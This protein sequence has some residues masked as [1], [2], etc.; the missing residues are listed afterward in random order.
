MALLD[1]FDLAASFRGRNLEGD[2][3]AEGGGVFGVSFHVDEREF[4]VLLGPSGSGKSVTLL[5]IL[6][7]LSDPPGITRGRVRYRGRSILPEVAEHFGRRVPSGRRWMRFRRAHL[8]L[9]APYRGREMAL[10]QQDPVGSLDPQRSIGSQLLTTARASRPDWDSSLARARALEV[11]RDVGLG[12]PERVYASYPDEL[13]GG[14]CQRA[15][16]AL[17]LLPEPSLLFADEPTSALDASSRL[18]VLD[19]LASLGRARGLATLLVTHDIGVALSY[20]TRIIVI[21]RGAVVEEGPV[22][23]FRKAAL[24]RGYDGWVASSLSR[25]VTG[26]ASDAREPPIAPATEALLEAAKSLRGAR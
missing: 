9:L 6:G 20:A 19:R 18:D 15:V 13:S 4:V 24:Q 7:L 21:E 14:Q 25:E 17:A 1:V 12:E 22:S 2:R 26:S 16:L 10:V 23:R 5:S 11:L 8:A 3:V